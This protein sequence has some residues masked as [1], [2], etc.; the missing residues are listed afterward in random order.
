M[1]R[2]VLAIFVARSSLGG[3]GDQNPLR[4]GRRPCRAI[5]CGAEAPRHHGALNGGLC[6]EIGIAVQVVPVCAPTCLVSPAGDTIR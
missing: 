5:G 2:D 4:R 1:A 3:E 6:R